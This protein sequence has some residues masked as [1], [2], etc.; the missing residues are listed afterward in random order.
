LADAGAPCVLLNNQHPGLASVMPDR[1]QGAE[2]AAR[3]LLA[4]GC[5]PIGL[6]AAD[7]RGAGAPERRP[8]LVGVRAACRAYGTALDERLVRVVSMH[9]GAAEETAALVRSLRESAHGT[10][11]GLVVFSYTLARAAA[12]GISDAGARVPADLGVVFG[13][14]DDRYDES[15]GLAPTVV[16]APKFEMAQAA[17]EMALG[18]LRG[19][20]AA[21][22]RRRLPMELRVRESCGS[23][24]GRLGGT[25]Q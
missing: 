18:R 15:L 25:I 24:R 20:S 1:A 23:P 19:E 16:H 5:G 17:I 22:D 11:P 3:H 4:L 12:Q 2:L 10:R 14:E 21:D 7:Y 9:L 6:L 13:D 8:E